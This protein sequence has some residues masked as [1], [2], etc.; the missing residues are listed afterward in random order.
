M[1]TEDLAEVLSAPGRLCIGPTD[2]SAAFPHGGTALGSVREVE[3]GRTYAWYDVTAEEFGQ[4]VVE[5]FLTHEA[6]FIRGIL[7]QYD[8]DA[9]GALFPNVRTGTKT[10]EAGMLHWLDAVGG[11]WSGA[12]AYT[13][14]TRVLVGGASYECILAH[15]NHTPPSATYW[16]VVTPV[17]PGAKMSD[18][19][20][21][22]LFSPLDADNVRGVILYRALPVPLPDAALQRFSWRDRAEVP[23]LFV[24]IPDATLR[25]ARHDFLPELPL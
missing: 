7:R 20:V 22:L 12:T 16:K 6:C 2:L 10:R 24:A 9:V 4:I 19:A 17:K 14:G 23:F 21:K 15:T 1:A 8:P 11:T 25:V 5:R 13:V 18:R 3:L